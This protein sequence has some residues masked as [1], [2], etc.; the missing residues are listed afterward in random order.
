M[1]ADVAAHV[2]VGNINGQNAEGGAAV[3]ALGQHG[4]A[5]Q[6][7]VLQH[8]L[9]GF[10]GADGGDDTLANAGDDGFLAGAAH[11]AGDIRAHSDPGLGPQLDAVLCHGGDG[12]RL[13][14]LG[15]NAH[16]HGLQHVAS[17]QVNSAGFLKGHIDVGLLGGD[18]GLG[19][20]LD[21]AA[22]QEVLFKLVHGD[23]QTGLAHHDQGVHQAMGRDAAQAHADQG[24][25]LD[26]DAAGH[27]ANPQ[28]DGHIPQEH[29]HQQQHDENDDK[30][31]YTRSIHF[32]SSPFTLS[33]HRS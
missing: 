32:L 22:R 9:V 26:F 29:Q 5:D 3:Q 8:G 1:S 30:Q 28:P 13:D 6:V 25:D 27:G 14:D 2:H 19:H 18:H 7:G 15:G 11:Q 20:A 21:V 23:I 12:R 16:L 31:G 33:S 4:L 10:G 17:G 24:A